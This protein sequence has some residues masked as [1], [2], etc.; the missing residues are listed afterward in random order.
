MG[1]RAKNKNESRALER[2]FPIFFWIQELAKEY[3]RIFKSLALF[4][5]NL[6]PGSG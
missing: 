4:L 5:E 3:E 2:A 1:T 6:I